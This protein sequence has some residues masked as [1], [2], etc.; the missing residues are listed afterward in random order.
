MKTMLA[1]AN[2][3]H[4]RERQELEQSLEALEAQLVEAQRRAEAAEVQAACLAQSQAPATEEK[5]AAGGSTP[6]WKAATQGGSSEASFVA[7][8]RRRRLVAEGQLPDEV[9]EGV[10]QLSESLCAAVE[11]LAN[12]LYESECHFLYEIIQ[13]AEDAHARAR[14]KEAREP[15]LSLRLGPPSPAFPHGFFLSENNE[16]GFTERDV[17]ALCDISASSKK[18]PMPGAEGGSI[19]CKGIGFKSVFTVSDRAHVLSKA[20]IEFRPRFLNGSTGLRQGCH[21]ELRLGEA[22]LAKLPPEV[23]EVLFLPLRASGLAAAI[24]QDGADRLWPA[25]MHMETEMDELAGPGRASLLF[26]R[27]YSAGTSL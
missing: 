5:A 7:A 19:G 24:G 25:Q 11:R 21:F 3:T 2:E 10:K 8:L 23:R 9:R 22:E 20:W 16:A 15:R 1:S 14:P 18:K 26:L 17:T 4:Q 13:N 27:S 6:P 12:D